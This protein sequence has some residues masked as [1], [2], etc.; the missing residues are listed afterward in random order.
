MLDLGT[1]RLVAQP[2]LCHS[3]AQALGGAELNVRWGFSSSSACSCQ[4]NN[5][6]GEALW[7]GSEDGVSILQPAN[8]ADARP[9]GS[10]PRGWVGRD[11]RVQET[12]VCV[13]RLMPDM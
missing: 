2:E 8:S 12:T 13:A 3:E 1:V 7:G 11:T 10:S 9:R 4:S 6:D 5:A